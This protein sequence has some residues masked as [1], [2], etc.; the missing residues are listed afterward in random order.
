MDS[1]ATVATMSNNIDSIGNNSIEPTP[2]T[3]ANTNKKPKLESSSTAINYDDEKGEYVVK[4]H[5]GLLRGKFKCNKHKIIAWD[6]NCSDCYMRRNVH[7]I[8]PEDD[9]TLDLQNSSNNNNDNSTATLDDVS[10]L[11]EWGTKTAKRHFCK[12]CGIL[13]WY[14]PRSNPDGY[15][16]TLYCVDWESSGSQKPIIEIKQYDGHNWEN[17]H[18]TTGISKL[19]KSK[20]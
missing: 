13:P 8:I 10:I 6:C 17:S 3:E 11:Y 12:V 1:A 4:C 7:I 20:K 16:I 5:C 19:S 2:S 9:F 14:R 18:K 15:G